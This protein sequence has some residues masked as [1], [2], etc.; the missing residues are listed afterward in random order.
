[1]AFLL[2][3]KARNSWIVVVAQLVEPSLPT[4][5]VRGSNPVIGKLLPIC[6]SSF[7]NRSLC[8]ILAIYLFTVNCI[9]NMKIKKKR[10]GIKNTD[11]FYIHFYSVFENRFFNEK[12]LRAITRSLE[13]LLSVYLVFGKILNQ[14]W[15]NFIYFG[16]I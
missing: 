11:F 3:T 5:E 1:M 2:E 10:P 9:E 6:M 13:L 4:A 14:L 15:Q 7:N 16:Q 8:F 12:R